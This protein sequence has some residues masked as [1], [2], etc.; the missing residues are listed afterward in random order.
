AGLPVF[1]GGGSGPTHLVGPTGGYL[2]GFMLSAMSA[3]WLAE[4][5][6]DR[7][8]AKAAMA[9][10]LSSVWVFLLGA[11]FLALHVGGPARA[12][13]LGV[14]PFLPGDVLKTA[15]ATALLPC[16]RPRIAPRQSR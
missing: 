6:W 13:Q 5:G 7:T 3:G 10:L 11:G 1:S 4:R 8:P 9:M 14:L 12:F 2:V 16:V 15:I